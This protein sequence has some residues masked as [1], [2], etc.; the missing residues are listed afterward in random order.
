MNYHE[1]AAPKVLMKTIS[2]K[3]V[4]EIL[5]A[6]KKKHHK[7][8]YALGFYNCLRVS[9][10]VNL[11]IEDIDFERRLIHIKQAKG[12]KDR[13]IPI[14]P[15]VKRGLKH[16]PV[17]VGIR[18]LQ[19]A[20]NRISKKVTGIRHKF[21]TLRHSGATYYLNEKK[22]NLRQVQVLLGHSRIS[23]TQIYTHLNPIDLVNQMWE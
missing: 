7:L 21:H 19:I 8:A 13:I 15:E 10:V 9:E 16:L 17:G 11:K 5:K 3:E 6:T 18:A 23:T 2:K 1:G 4:D 12:K 22:W 20:F 14:A